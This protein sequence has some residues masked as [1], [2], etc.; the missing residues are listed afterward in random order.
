MADVDPETV[1]YLFLALTG[2]G[3]L[4]A[5][6][7]WRMGVYVGIFLDV[8]RD[9]ARKLC[10]GQSITITLAGAAVW[11]FVAW[12]AWS[13]EGA[14][15]KAFVREHPTWRT[16]FIFLMLALLP[17]AAL[18]CIL[19]PRGYLLAAIGLVSYTGP[20]IGIGM[21]FLFA[22]SEKDVYRFL[23]FYTIINTVALVGVPLECFGWH[24]PGLGGI[25]YQ[26]IRYS[27]AGTIPLIA[28]FY[29]SPDI[30][31]LHAAHVMMFSMM[32]WMRKARG[33][34][35]GW[36]AAVAWAAYCVLLSGRRKMIGIPIVFVI[37]YI[38]LCVW[39]QAHHGQRLLA[40]AILG[41]MVAIGGAFIFL[42]AE[43]IRDHTAYATT[44]FTEGPQRFNELVIGSTIATVKRV[45][46]LG[47]GLGSATQGRYYIGLDKVGGG[48]GWQE[49]G[50]SRMFL[51]FGV[52]GTILVLFS[53]FM[54]IQMTSRALRRVPRE[55]SVQILQFGLL[56]VVM[57]NAASF[58]ISHQQYSGDPVTGLMATMMAGMV[59]GLTQVY[60]RRTSKRRRRGQEHSK[61]QHTKEGMA[62]ETK[63]GEA[64]AS[65]QEAG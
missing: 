18:S 40:L 60:R 63:V 49:D 12:R 13:T 62:N 43:D 25:R 16:I 51:E 19:Y 2:V 24:V 3:C 38:G 29:R 8:L 50:V 56:S 32:L 4:I 35:V 52:A 34:S 61:Q 42:N 45:G 23:R 55:S 11:I 30:M 57:G 17:A 15:I 36:F 6:S 46:F 9:P 59:L 31:G 39:R 65:E 41:I 48:A 37:S 33:G 21:G 54:A 1:E 58:V 64:P 28:G 10:E 7:N 5:I 47:A 22:R 53:L 26:W 20:I 14:S 44:L 27:E